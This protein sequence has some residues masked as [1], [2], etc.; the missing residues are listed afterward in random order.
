MNP[1]LFFWVHGTD[2]ADENGH[3][4]LPPIK[5]ETCALRLLSIS[6]WH[7]RFSTKNAAWAPVGKLRIHRIDCIEINMLRMTAYTF[8][9]GENNKV[10]S[11][12]I[13]SV[14][15]RCILFSHDEVLL[16]T[17]L[18]AGEVLCPRIA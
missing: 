7:A 1:F 10:S 13:Q 17:Q 14:K 6:N 3:A 2:M 8:R 15:R 9:M 4:S 5:A 18:T 11:I 12:R 16:S